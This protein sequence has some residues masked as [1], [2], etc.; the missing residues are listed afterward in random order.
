MKSRCLMIKKW[1]SSIM[2][3]DDDELAVGKNQTR[4]GEWIEITMRKV[5]N[6]SLGLIEAPTYPEC[7]KESDSKPQ[8]PLPPLKVLHGAS[9]SSEVMPLTYSQHSPKD[10]PRLV[11]IG[12]MVKVSEKPHIL[13]LKR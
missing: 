5:I 10:R 9:P 11:N 6:E 3:L 4:N 13:E 12:H 7:S 2:A 8:T 1:F